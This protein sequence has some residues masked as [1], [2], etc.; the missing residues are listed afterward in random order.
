[1][2]YAP[3]NPVE[4]MVGVDRDVTVFTDAPAGAGQANEVRAAV[5]PAGREVAAPPRSSA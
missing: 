5:R 1:M 2:K 4:V 3:G